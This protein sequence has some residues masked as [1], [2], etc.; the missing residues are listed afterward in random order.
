M[1]AVGS[2]VNRSTHWKLTNR[3]N[4]LRFF[5]CISCIVLLVGWFFNHELIRMLNVEVVKYF[6]VKYQYLREA[7]EENHEKLQSQQL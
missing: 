3:P 5:N 2:A 7:S 4:F 1:N 6:K